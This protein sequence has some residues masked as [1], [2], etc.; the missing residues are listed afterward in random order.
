VFVELFVEVFVALFVEVFVE[1]FVEVFVALLVE[2]FVELFVELFVVVLLDDGLFTSSSEHEEINNPATAIPSHG[3][4]IRLS[5]RSGQS[6]HASKQSTSR[7]VSPCESP[8]YAA[9]QPDQI[10]QAP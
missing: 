8:K 7:F 5:L 4:L 6:N 10:A 3:I 1:L 9:L 2:V